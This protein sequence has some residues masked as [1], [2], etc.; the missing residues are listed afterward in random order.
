MYG[1]L[2]LAV[3]IALWLAS[4]SWLVSE[5]VLPPLRVGDPP[6]YGSVVDA[7]HQRPPVGWRM[8]FNGRPLGWAVTSIEE[9]PTGGMS[10]RSRVRFDRLPLTEMTP[11]WIFALWRVIDQ[12]VPTMAMD[13][14]S[15]ADVTPAGNLA[16]FRSLV[17]LW[18]MDTLI[19][20]NGRQE[21][22]RLILSVQ[23]ADV[24]CTTETYLQPNSL[25]GEALSPQSQLPG[26]H[27]GRAWTVPI[28]SP[29]RPPNS[30]LEI[31]CATVEGLETIEWQGRAV[32]AWLVA[33]RKES[34]FASTRHGRPQG[35]LWVTRDGDVLQ[36]EAV[37]MDRALV[38]VRLADQES[39][40]LIRQAA[41][42]E[43]PVSSTP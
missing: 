13:V 38:F 17:H 27:E 41:S 35:R 8:L 42:L 37:I 23:A 36:Q 7:T 25:L 31:Y 29:L 22:S 34:G 21:E 20:L 12:P 5:K 24:T 6:S 10:L 33:Y 19:E 4:M 14:E 11:S 15:T 16:R 30:P 2:Y 26:M 40:E 28:Y 18:P 9:L 3:V 32:E 43:S 39:Q 1:R